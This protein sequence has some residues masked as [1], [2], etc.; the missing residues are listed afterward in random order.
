[1][2]D[3]GGA[4]NADDGRVSRHRLATSEESERAAG[5]AEQRRG[6]ERGMVAAA[7]QGARRKTGGGALRSRRR[8]K[9][10]VLS[11]RLTSA[12][13]PPFLLP[14]YGYRLTASYIA[15]PATIGLLFSGREAASSGARAEGECPVYVTFRVNLTSTENNS[16]RKNE[17]TTTKWMSKN[18]GGREND[19]E[20]L[21]RVGRRV[22]SGQT[23]EASRS[24]GIENRM[25]KDFRW[26]CA[27]MCERESEK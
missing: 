23:E 21:E 17:D 9:S 19:V 5:N 8:C 14:F 12:S 13:S 20:W 15:L 6:R 16:E 11:T 18:V 7:A 25:G 3:D 4:N 24:N 27:E 26:H 1:M 10:R 2:E 22:K